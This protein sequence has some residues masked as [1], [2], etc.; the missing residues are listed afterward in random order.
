MLSVIMLIAEK[1]PQ[2]SL[3]NLYDSKERLRAPA[4][5]RREIQAYLHQGVS[6]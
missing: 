4:Q 3:L 6:T 1:Y 5:H 2:L